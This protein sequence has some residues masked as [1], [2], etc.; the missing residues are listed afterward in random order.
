M[1]CGYMHGYSNGYWRERELLGLQRASTMRP[2]EEAQEGASN[3]IAAAYQSWQYLHLQGDVERGN[4]I[5]AA[6]QKRGYQFLRVKNEERD[7][8]S[9]SVSHLQLR[10]RQVLVDLHEC[11]DDLLHSRSLCY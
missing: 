11:R 7:L 10:W 8:V 6:R 1:E 3:G 4:C 9:C 5:T 2:T